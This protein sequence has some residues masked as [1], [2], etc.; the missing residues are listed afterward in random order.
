MATVLVIDDSA[1]DRKPLAKLLK[2]HGYDVV[3]ASNAYEAMAAFK[4]KTPDLIL[5]DVMIPPMDGLTFLMLL[6]QEESG[7]DIPVIVLTGLENQNTISRAH[8]LGVRELLVKSQFDPAQLLEL[9]DKHLHCR[10]AG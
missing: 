3:T 7:K 10:P 2:V 5:L 4:R 1:R 6:R 9:I 8:D